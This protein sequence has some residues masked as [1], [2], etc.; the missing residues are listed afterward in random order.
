MKFLILLLAALAG[1]TANATDYRAGED[2]TLGFKAVYMGD[3]FEGRFARFTPA[4]RFDPADLAG[5][6]FDVRIDLASASTDNQER[7]EML[8][9]PDFF[10][11]GAQPEARYQASRFTALGGNRFRAEGTLTLNGDSRPVVLDFT[12]TAGA[13][14]VLEGRATLKRLDFGVGEGDWA[15][16]DLL[17]D[18]VE[19]F[20]R[21]ALQPGG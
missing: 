10:N 5:S 6:R 1:T 2:S 14:A 18:E 17:P 11:A 12:W 19:V 16:T 20:T 13:P 8:V 4:I 15:D 9:G 21:L 3:T 7:D